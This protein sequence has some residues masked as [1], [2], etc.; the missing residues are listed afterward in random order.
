MV[1]LKCDVA[2]AVCLGE[3]KNKM[4]ITKAGLK[5]RNEL[6]CLN[7]NTIYFQIH[8]LRN[9]Y[10]NKI[11]LTHASRL[12][13][14]QANLIFIYLTHSYLKSGIGDAFCQRSCFEYQEKYIEI[15][16]SI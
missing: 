11:R 15:D 8:C 13:I 5:Q 9:V 12:K 3:K 6:K 16:R 14:I 2:D 7:L 4:K 1:S 10:Y